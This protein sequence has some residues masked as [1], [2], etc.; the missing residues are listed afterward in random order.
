MSCILCGKEE[1]GERRL[2]LEGKVLTLCPQHF[3]LIER[4]RSAKTTEE[5]D[6]S[7]SN[8]NDMLNS[9]PEESR[10]LIENYINN[11]DPAVADL[12]E[13]KKDI[14]VIKGI[15]IIFLVVMILSIL[16]SFIAGYNISKAIDEATRPSYNYDLDDYDSGF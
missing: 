7:M 15:A 14:A 13:L 2:V 5:F 6:K 4:A 12:N 16:F 9:L 10:I 3:N 1:K 11:S 8:L